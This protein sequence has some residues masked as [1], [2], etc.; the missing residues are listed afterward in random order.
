MTET[1]PPPVDAPRLMLILEDEPL[2]I[3]SI[4][5]EKCG[6]FAQALARISRRW[7]Q[8]RR[9]SSRITRSSGGALTR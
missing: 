4:E 2:R 5:E 6:P 9:W 1:S 8:V 7:P 3:A